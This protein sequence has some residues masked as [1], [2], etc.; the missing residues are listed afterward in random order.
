MRPLQ[1]SKAA[2]AK[3]L[4]KAAENGNQGIGSALML[5][6]NEEA[7]TKFGLQPNKFRIRRQ[8]EVHQFSMSARSC[9]LLPPW[10]SGSA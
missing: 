1:Q 8:G 7:P 6:A 2:D 3:G 4:S 10:P 5:R 9:P